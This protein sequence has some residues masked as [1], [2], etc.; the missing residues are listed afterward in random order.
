MLSRRSGTGHHGFMER[1]TATRR[2]DSAA[3]TRRLLL[4][5]AQELFTA[6]GYRE[7]SIADIA[8]AA[9]VAVATVYTSVGGKPALLQSLL[10]SGV[11]TPETSEAMDEVAHCSDA[12]EVIDLAAHGTRLIVER[13]K[14]MIDLIE[15]TRRAEPVAS[16]AAAQATATFRTALRVAAEQLSAL[17][18]LRRDAGVDRAADVMWYFFGLESWTRLV[19]DCGW[20]WSEAEDFLTDAAKR[21]LLR[22]DDDV[23]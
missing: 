20:S 9:G 3:E 5:A 15:C 22:S 1:R 13:H 17:D 12:E 6:R 4:D 16:E 21:S 2:Q 23:S 11:E 18:S 10:S 14:A 7:T 8:S 19:D